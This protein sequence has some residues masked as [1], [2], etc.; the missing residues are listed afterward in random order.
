MKACFWPSSTGKALLKLIFLP[1]CLLAFVLFPSV[2]SQAAF[3]S[4]L[5]S[6]WGNDCKCI[7]AV[8]ATLKLLLIKLVAFWVL[9][10]DSILCNYIWISRSNN[11]GSYL[12][13]HYLCL[14]ILSQD[15]IFIIKKKKACNILEF[16][17]DVWTHWHE[18]LWWN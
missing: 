2:I 3:S 7:D 11:C 17:Y 13:I 10:Q 4:L 6:L 5:L 18:I 9:K 15:A 1:T 12:V 16:G 14:N 8:M